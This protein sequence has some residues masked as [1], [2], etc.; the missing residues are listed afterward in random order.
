MQMLNPNPFVLLCF[1]WTW[2]ILCSPCL[3]RR[4]GMAGSQMHLF[5]EQV[6]VDFHTQDFP[7]NHSKCGSSPSQCAYKWVNSI[8]S[9]ENCLKIPTRHAK[10]MDW[11][12]GVLQET[13]ALCDLVEYCL[14]I[15]TCS[16]LSFFLNVFVL[17]LGTY[18][19]LIPSN[20]EC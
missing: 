15:A 3:L 13:L 12:G 6:C 20:I 9:Q 17:F 7:G 5:S 16:F 14:G 1:R 11:K 18:S 4:R 2:W 10:C 8:L 19:S